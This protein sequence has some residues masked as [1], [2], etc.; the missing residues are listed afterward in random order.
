MCDL[1]VKIK[2]NLQL[3]LMVL[4]PERIINGPDLDRTG[5]DLDQTGTG[6]GHGPGPDL[7]WIWTSKGPAQGRT[8]S[9]PRQN[10]VRTCTKPWTKLDRIWI[11]SLDLTWAPEGESSRLLAATSVP[12]HEV[13]LL[14]TN[15][16]FLQN[17]LKDGLTGF[18]CGVCERHDFILAFGNLRNAR[19]ETLVCK[20]R[21]ELKLVKHSLKCE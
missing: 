6:P 17:P 15:D 19:D 18:R 4:S 12:H 20:N 13:N 21:A 7:D 3:L 16:L 14:K 5:P 10:L 1:Y 8:C 2:L 9:G 11:A